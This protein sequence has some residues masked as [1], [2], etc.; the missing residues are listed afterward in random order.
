M[1]MTSPNLFQW[2]AW[3]QASRPRTLTAALVPIWVGS[4]LAL[5][6]TG[7]GSARLG[8]F[9]L[10]SSVLIQVGTNLINDAMDFKKG[11]DTA[12]RVG[13]K[14]VTQSGVFRVEQVWWAGL[15]CF[16][17]AALLG[18]PLVMQGGWP[19]IAVGCLSLLAGYAYTGGPYP[20]AYRGWGD[21]FVLVF[22]GWVAVGGMYYLNTGSFHP[23]AW[24][25]GTQVGM[26]AT[27][28]IAINNARD[29]ET[30]RKVGKMTLAARFGVGFAQQEIRLLFLATYLLQF[31]WL[32]QKMIWAF[33]FPLGL[34]PRVVFLLWRLSRVKPGAA[35]NAL[36]GQS[37][38]IHLAFG[39]LLGLGLILS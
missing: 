37:A 21:F 26:L 12:E 6:M 25:A 18:L 36:L 28:L 20:L 35:F 15:F 17:L 30:D 11:A 27:V 23:A 33:Y 32:D 22:F 16:F 19:I 7:M 24:V 39:G 3:L 14:R 8:I 4:A 10:L 13:P 1:E 2:K 38:L 5:K 29:A 31:Y 34:L 9:A